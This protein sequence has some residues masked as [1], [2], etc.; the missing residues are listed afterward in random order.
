MQEKLT[1][2]GPQLPDARHSL[3]FS[4]VRPESSDQTLSDKTAC[5][6]SSTVDAHQGK[7]QLMRE[8]ACDEPLEVW[9]PF[10]SYRRVKL[11][12][13]ALQTAVQSY[14]LDKK[15]IYVREEKQLKSKEHMYIKMI[16]IRI[17]QQVNNG[18]N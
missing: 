3:D 4:L 16:I 5:R 2:R 10:H 7:G 11:S 1:V 18:I 13:Q 8:K 6:H 14:F 9:Y 12:M 15:S 17:T